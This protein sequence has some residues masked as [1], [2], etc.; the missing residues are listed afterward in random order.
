MQ[1]TS[2]TRKGQI[3]IPKKVRQQFGICEGST[4]IFHI[5][6]NHIELQVES[7]TVNGFGMLKS[8]RKTIPND[9]DSAKLLK[10]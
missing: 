5:I 10:S 3:T 7:A 2:V 8:N 4:V 6:D 9:F 1:Q